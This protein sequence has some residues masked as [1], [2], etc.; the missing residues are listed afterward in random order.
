MLLVEV[1]DMI[2]KKQVFEIIACL[3]QDARMKMKAL[4]EKTKVPISTIFDRVHN[5]SSLGITRLSALLDFARLGFGSCSTVL[6]KAGTGRRDALKEFL[7]KA[8]FVNSLMRV[9]NGFDFMAEL[10][11]H[12]MK[13]QDAFLELLEKEYGVKK[14]VVH[15]VIEELKREGLLSDISQTIEVV[16]YE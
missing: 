11:F 3:R 7:M 16:R 9:N 5:P 14:P 13:E 12:D 2:P 1:I 10:V 6:M 8:P 15:F 4:S